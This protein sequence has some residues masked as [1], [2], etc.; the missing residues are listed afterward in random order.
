MVMSRKPNHPSSSKKRNK[1][2][3]SEQT[4][5]LLSVSISDNKK[6]RV[7]RKQPDRE[8]EKTWSL[9]AKRCKM[10]RAA[11][12]TGVCRLYSS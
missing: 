8:M 9:L 11:A 7:N 4:S 6:R 2:L 5:L 10:K 3:S 12:S 1:V